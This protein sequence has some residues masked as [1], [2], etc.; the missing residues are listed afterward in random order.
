MSYVEETNHIVP[1]TN[2]VEQSARRCEEAGGRDHDPLA[3][4]DKVSL[5]QVREGTQA[6][7]LGTRAVSLGQESVAVYRGHQNLSVVLADVRAYKFF[8]GKSL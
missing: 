6:K 8:Q 2:R 4:G 1:L 5:A 7:R 3:T